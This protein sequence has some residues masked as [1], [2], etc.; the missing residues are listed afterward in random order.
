VIVCSPWVR[1]LRTGS[2]CRYMANS[3]YVAAL[4]MP[5]D[6]GHEWNLPHEGARGNHEDPI[7]AKEQA[8]AALR[9]RG[10]VLRDPPSGFA[11]ELK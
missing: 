4:V 5:M 3:E 10:Y 2:V 7:V 8:D 11:K 1:D 6:D 9:S